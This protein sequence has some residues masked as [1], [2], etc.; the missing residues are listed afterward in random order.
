MTESSSGTSQGDASNSSGGTNGGGSGGTWQAPDNGASNSAD[1]G[2]N[3]AAQGNQPQNS[4]Q[5]N[6]GGQG[7]TDKGFPENTPIAEMTDAQ[8]AAY[9]KYHNRKA[10]NALSAYKGVTPEQ[11]EQMQTQLQQYEEAQLSASDKALRDA[12]KAG[13]DAANAEWL[14]KY[15]RSEL[16]GYASDVLKGEQLDAFLAGVNPAVFADENGEINREKVMGHLT[17]MFGL[18]GNNGQHAGPGSGYTGAAGQ[19]AGRSWGQHSGGSG[20]PPAKPGE[21]GKA[22]AAQRH[23]IKT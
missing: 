3:G 15:Q 6:Q 9:F 10:E 4:G 1:T 20:A 16:R 17:A 5:G 7:G 13:R 21:A 8:R 19:G 22:A 11:V 12:E 18:G 2:T 14:P 23:G